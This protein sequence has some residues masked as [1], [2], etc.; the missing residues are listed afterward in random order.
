MKEKETINIREFKP[1]TTSI[2]LKK[3]KSGKKTKNCKV[4][5]CDNSCRVRFLFNSCPG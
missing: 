5:L 2:L 3:L 1:T 4:K